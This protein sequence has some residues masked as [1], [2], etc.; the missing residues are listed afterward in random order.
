MKNL[1]EAVLTL[2]EELRPM[3][4]EYGPIFVEMGEQAILD[5]I[6]MLAQG[7]VR[8]AYKTLLEAMPNTALLDE[9]TTLESEWQ[10]EVRRNFERLAVV[11]RAQ[12]ALMGALLTIALALVGL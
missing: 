3:A 12:S 6:K 10:A 11:R 2:P 7:D 4:L 1:N 8:E 5:W 9:W